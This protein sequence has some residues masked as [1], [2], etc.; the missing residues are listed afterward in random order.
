MPPFTIGLIQ[1]AVAS[2]KAA[3]IDAAVSAI[4]AAASRGAQIICLQELFDAP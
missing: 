3:T 1:H 4:R 2:D